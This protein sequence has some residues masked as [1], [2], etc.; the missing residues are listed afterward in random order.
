MSASGYIVEYFTCIGS[1]VSQLHHC[2]CLYRGSSSAITE[3]SEGE[4]LDV[5]IWTRST[6][7]GVFRV[8]DQE[9]KLPDWVNDFEV[10]HCG[11]SDAHDKPSE[12]KLTTRR[13]AGPAKIKVKASSLAGRFTNNN[14]LVAWCVYP[15]M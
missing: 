5:I 14:F 10:K 1:G 13:I 11:G 8:T 7:G 9:K 6:I 3:I 12:F 4:F 2:H 15:H